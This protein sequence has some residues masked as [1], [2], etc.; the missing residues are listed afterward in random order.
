MLLAAKAKSAALLWLGSTRPQLDAFFV[1]LTTGAPYG[2]NLALMNSALATHFHIDPA[3]VAA[4]KAIMINHIRTTFAA[5]EATLRDS[6]TTFKFRTDAEAALD[7]NPSVDAAYTWP[8]PPPT[9]APRINI[10]RTFPTRPELNRISSI[11]HEAVHVNDAGS[12]TPQTH[13]SEWYVTDP[14]AAAFGWS[15]IAPMPVT[16]FATRYDLMV[17]ADA[18]H[19]PASYATFARHIFGNADTRELP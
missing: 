1:T 2:F 5:I 12:A 17:T 8:F 6:A 11:L 15:P 19:N 16:T 4:T 14:V 13:I 18:I 3:Q 10:T 9:P 7:G